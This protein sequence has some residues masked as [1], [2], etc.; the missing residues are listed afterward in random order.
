[1]DRWVQVLQNPSLAYFTHSTLFRS[2]CRGLVAPIPE[3]ANLAIPTQSSLDAGK[4]PL[5]LLTGP[6]V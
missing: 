3:S 1:M 5:P 2:Y 6:G 4:P